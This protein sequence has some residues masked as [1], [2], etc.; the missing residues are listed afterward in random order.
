MAARRP[1]SADLAAECGFTGFGAPSSTAQSSIR[2]SQF[3]CVA[4]RSG[5]RRECGS[6]AASA[7]CERDRARGFHLGTTLCAARAARDMLPPLWCECVLFRGVPLLLVYGAGESRFTAKTKEARSMLA[8]LVPSRPRKAGY[9][10]VVHHAG[11]HLSSA[12]HGKH[13]IPECELILLDEPHRRRQPFVARARRLAQHL[14]RHVVKRRHLLAKVSYECKLVGARIVDGGERGE[15]GIQPSAH[16]PPRDKVD[17]YCGRAL[18]SLTRQCQAGPVA[19]VSLCLCSD[20]PGGALLLAQTK[21]LRH[22]EQQ[23]GRIYLA[24]EQ[25]LEQVFAPAGRRMAHC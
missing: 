21:L 8:P 18:G 9:C 22:G 10:I 1:T 13:G 14:H 23:I 3:P 7:T 25:V 6:S 5:S 11:S 15:R 12:I 2:T 16:A 17:R 4:G 19:R 20:W 24:P